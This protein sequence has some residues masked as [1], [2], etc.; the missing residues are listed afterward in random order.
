MQ[1][2]HRK[3]KII[4]KAPVT[5]D[6]GESKWIWMTR[7][8]NFQKDSLMDEELSVGAEKTLL[9]QNMKRFAYMFSFHLGRYIHGASFYCS[10][11]R[12]ARLMELFPFP[13]GG[14]KKEGLFPRVRE[15]FTV[16]F[17]LFAAPP[18]MLN[19]GM[20]SNVFRRCVHLFKFGIK[21]QRYFAL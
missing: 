9:R 3:V 1:E 7:G 18:E 19:E 2:S 17:W 6:C 11:S 4:K 10:G 21:Q 8:G 5:S 13:V 12:N 15:D 16:Q 14:V 20:E